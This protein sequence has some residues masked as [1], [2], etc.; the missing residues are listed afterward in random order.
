MKIFRWELKLPFV[1]FWNWLK[2][3]IV[4]EK[5]GTAEESNVDFEIGV[6]TPAAK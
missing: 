6:N 5:E 1:I 3:V 4:F 2:I